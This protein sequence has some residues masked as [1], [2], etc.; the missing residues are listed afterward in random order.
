MKLN[1]FIL[2]FVVICLNTGS[3]IGQS[4][5]NNNLIIS[6]LQSLLTQTRQNV[7]DYL[8]TILVDS[9]I[10]NVDAIFASASL[11]LTSVVNKNYGCSRLT[12][13]KT[14]TSTTT[15]KSNFRL[16]LISF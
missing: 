9:I 15:I 13:T 16:L 6:E 3:I 4:A 14:T 12:T 7:R 5:N 2:C 10:K 8:S 11:N 1:V